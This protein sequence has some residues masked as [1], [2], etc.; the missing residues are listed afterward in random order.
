MESDRGKYVSGRM[1]LNETGIY[2][3]GKTERKREEVRTTE[4]NGLE[5]SMTKQ[6]TRKSAFN[7]VRQLIQDIIQTY[8]QFVKQSI[9]FHFRLV[10]FRS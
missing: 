9:S 1:I 2:E 10:N 8:I 5:Y 6:L 3:K 7:F 4:S